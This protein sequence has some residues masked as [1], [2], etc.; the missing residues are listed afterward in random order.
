MP[1]KTC[2]A[3]VTGG[4]SG[5][6]RAICL[7]LAR[8][9]WNLAI[10]DVNEAGARET[11]EQVEQAGGSGHV[12]TF[13][14]TDF[15]QWQALRE[16]LRARWQQLDLLVNNAGVAGAGAVS[17]YSIEDW[18]WMMGVNLWN[19]IYGCHTLVPWLKENPRGAHIINTAS[20][21]SFGSLPTMAAYNVTK[22]GMVALSETLYAELKNSGIG[23]TVLCPAFFRTNLLNEARFVREDQRDMGQ[24]QFQE[25]KMTADNVAAAAI[26]A[27][28]KKRLYVV[29][30]RDARVHWYMKRLMPARVMNRVA[31]AFRNGV[32]KI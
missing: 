12:E 4:A 29:M 5:L 30:P 24:K 19:G 28:H 15:D 7:R 2:N 17:E 27:M 11:L 18:R 16:R 23:V 22:A 9:G 8:D 26:D 20:A 1:E 10:C 31:A 32:L 21:A 25:A 14:V 13:D 3:I 6:G